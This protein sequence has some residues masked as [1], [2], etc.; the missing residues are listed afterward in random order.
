MTEDRWITKRE[1]AT[2][3]GV[4][5]RTIERKAR[6]GKINARARPG[7][8]TLYLAAHVENLSQT[9]SQ[10]VRIGLLEDG[11]TGNGTGHGSIASLRG[12]APLSEAWFVDVL[13][14]LR[15]AL[16]HDPI[17]PTGPTSA[18]TGP[19]AA[20]VDK[21]EALAI[22]GVSYG[23]LREAVKAGEVKQRGWRYRRKDLEAL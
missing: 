5:E 7:F 18:P 17:G 2:L 15:A 3:A 19:T 14:A 21:V 8:P 22:A 12:P 13:Q 10:E 16:T 9:G 20:Y 23:A 6:A 11:P 4:D 1:A